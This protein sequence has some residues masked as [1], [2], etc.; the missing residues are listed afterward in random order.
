MNFVVPKY[1]DAKFRKAI[2]ERNGTFKKGDLQ[3]A[4]IEAIL[5]WCNK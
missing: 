1:V 5:E 4:L 2:Y 3:K